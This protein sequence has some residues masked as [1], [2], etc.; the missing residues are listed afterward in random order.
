MVYRNDFED[1]SLLF[2]PGVPRPPRRLVNAPNHTYN[3]R[4]LNIRDLVRTLSINGIY[5]ARI[6]EILT[7]PI[8]DADILTYRH[9]II[10]DLLRTPSLAE[11]LESILK[12]IINLENYLVE[13]QWEESELRKVAWRLSELENYVEGVVKLND[14][15]NAVGDHLHS[16][17]LRI[18]RD[19]VNATAH[20][21]TFIRLRKELPE[22]SAQFRGIA[23]ITIGVNLDDELRP[24]EA[25]L[26][27]INTS[28]FRGKSMLDWFFRRK[29]NEDDPIGPLHRAPPDEALMRFGQ[30]SPQMQTLFQ[31]LETVL[32]DIAKPISK[33]LETYTTVNA[34]MIVNLKVE[35]AFYLG[36]VKLIRHIQESG[37]PVCRPQI[38]PM[39][40][41]AC[42]LQAF[43]NVG[44]LL[45]QSPLNRPRD[46]SELI[47][48]NDLQFNE[49]GRI[50][51]LTGPNRG[52]KTTYTVALGL[53]QVLFQAGLYVPAQSA[54]MSP[55]DGIY[56]H[57]ATVEDP[58]LE[59]G[60]LGEESI[61]LNKVFQYATRN[62]LI[63]LNETFSSTSSV[64]SVILCKD[65]VRVLRLMGVRAIFATHLHE[66]AA[67]T[68]EINREIGGDSKIISMVSQVDLEIDDEGERHRRTYRILPGPPVGSSYA[69]EIAARYGISYHKLTAMLR[70]RDILPQETTAHSDS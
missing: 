55:V 43:Y 16:T 67:D 47:I 45:Q 21:E 66:L 11:Q 5:E 25:M 23:S 28:R 29:P 61:R 8:M 31:D 41:R 33:V 12:V 68:D 13:P 22:Y 63:L 42:D 39:E 48:T 54:T 1:T 18:L 49:D 15:L 27:T 14:L 58:R 34:R 59:A 36:A 64:E 62:S 3:L 32:D 30:E 37:M 65:V 17:G 70:E 50:F 6:E 2:P 19:K 51:I 40:A 4:D 53:A 46:L 35:I 52:G 24:R 10:D 20:D 9:E 60:R 26:L 38:R 7:T 57:F 69:R 44:L 56:T